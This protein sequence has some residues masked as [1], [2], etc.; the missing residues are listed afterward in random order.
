[1]VTVCHRPASLSGGICGPLAVTVRRGAAEKG[2]RRLLPKHLPPRCDVRCT[3]VI[4]AVSSFSSRYIFHILTILC[5]G[6]LL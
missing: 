1:M 5:H 2:G 6:E 4:T 3:L